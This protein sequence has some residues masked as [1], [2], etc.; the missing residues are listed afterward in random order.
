MRQVSSKRELAE[1]FSL[2]GQC[3]VFVRDHDVKAEGGRFVLKLLDE[4]SIASMS[5]FLI[6]SGNG[7]CQLSRGRRREYWGTHGDTQLFD[8]RLDFRC[9]LME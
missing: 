4:F 3:K 8:R 5:L 2:S 6:I 7:H 1:V 9:R